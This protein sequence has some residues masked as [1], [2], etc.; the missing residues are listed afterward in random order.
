[1]SSLHPLSTLSPLTL[2]QRAVTFEHTMD[3][4]GSALKATRCIGMLSQ[5]GVARFARKYPP[6]LEALLKSVLELT[7]K[8]QRSFVEYVSSC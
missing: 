6:V 1:M 3:A 4:T 8:Y 2:L 5:L 7:C